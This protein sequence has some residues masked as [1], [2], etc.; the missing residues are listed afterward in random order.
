MMTLKQQAYIQR[1]AEDL[2]YRGDYG[3]TRAASHVLGTMSPSKISRKGLTV[4]EAS[5]VI[6]GL[7]Q[8]LAEEED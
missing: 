8:L 3:W 2:G 7:K 1:L 4:R 6:D 5:E